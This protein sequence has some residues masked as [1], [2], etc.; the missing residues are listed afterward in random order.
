VISEHAVLAVQFIVKLL[1]PSKPQVITQVENYNAHVKRVLNS[2][3]SGMDRLAVYR[4]QRS[5][6]LDLNPDNVI[7]ESSSEDDCGNCL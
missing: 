5:V 6:K 2:N 4:T 7:A 3:T 1:V